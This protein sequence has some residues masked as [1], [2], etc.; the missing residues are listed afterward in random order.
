MKLG[1]DVPAG[2]PRR[3]REFFHAKTIDLNN[4]PELCRVTRV[5]G[6]QVWYRVGV[7]DGQ[8]GSKFKCSLDY[9]SREVLG[10]W[11]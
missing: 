3:G 5:S 7:R 11:K 2:G 6:G 8:P 4:Q 1:E 10:G 9:F